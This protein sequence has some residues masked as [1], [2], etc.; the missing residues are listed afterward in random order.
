MPYA[1]ITTNV[2]KDGVNAVEVSS[3]VAKTLEEVWGIPAAVSM[4][5]QPAKGDLAGSL[6]QPAA[7]VNAYPI[8][9]DRKL[10]PKAIAALTTTVS[11]QLKVPAERIYVVLGSVEVGYWGSGRPAWHRAP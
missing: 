3:A 4:S 8:G 1:R 5:L 7:F 11:E 10:N 2:S 6:L 9:L